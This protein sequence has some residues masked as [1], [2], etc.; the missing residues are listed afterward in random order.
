M[1]RQIIVLGAGISGLA[2]AWYLKQFLGSDAP[3]HVI[4]K[5][6]RP[7]GWI[8]TLQTE[9]YLF[10]QGPRSCRSKGAGQET[11]ALIENLGLEDQVSGPSL[12]CAPIAI[13]ML[14]GI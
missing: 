2:I 13:F 5:S 3:V 9:G 10:E 8:Q 4:E 7:G 14:M 6:S 1:S 11:L 12:G